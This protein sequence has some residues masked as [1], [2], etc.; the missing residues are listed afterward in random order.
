MTSD[1]DGRT[2]LDDLCRTTFVTHSGV[3]GNI[4]PM[5]AI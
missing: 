1:L 5:S 4:Q 2:R 3:D